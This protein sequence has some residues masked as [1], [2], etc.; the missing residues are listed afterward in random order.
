MAKRLISLTVNGEKVERAVDERTLLIHFLREDLALKGA[1]IGC[2]TSHCGACT[3]DVDGKSVKSCTVFAVQAEGA[4][5]RTIEGV[6]NADGSLHALQDAFR[7]EHGLQCGYCTP[8][9]IMRAYRLLQENPSPTDAEIRMG[10]AGNLCR[11][12]GYQNIVNAIR[13][14][15]SAM[16]VREAAE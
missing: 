2:D 11:C 7:N 16:K 3:V 9:M 4:Q 8:G 6:A 15:A 13:A 1:H 10:I 5:I 12:T 14:A